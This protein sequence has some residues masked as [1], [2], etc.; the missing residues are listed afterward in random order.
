MTLSKIFTLFVALLVSVVGHAACLTDM[1][2]VSD[3]GRE[4]F[5]RGQYLLAAQQYSSV[6]LLSCPGLQQ[7]S[8]RLRWG[9]SL[10]ELEE[11]DE[12]RLI[13]EKLNG[14]SLERQAHLVQA[15]YQPSLRGRL[16]PADQ[17]KFTE[18]DRRDLS[19]L[20]VKIPWVAGTLS[21]LVPGAGQVYNGNF[22]SAVFS[23]LLN[24]IFLSTTLDFHNR[25]M[26]APAI[27]S[28]MVFS[29][30][31]LGNIIGSVRSAQ[32][33]NSAAQAPAEAELKHKLFPEL[34][35]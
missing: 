35:N 15:W 27:A 1:N 23:F 6:A 31:Y 2:A 4:F 14:T 16:T 10:Y 19:S 9:Q 7:Y 3:Q 13:L 25:H 33:L 18:W 26:D 5:S 29:V 21:A 24:A 34:N 17:I 22:Q 11:A 28:G 30:V 12:G 32:A 8:A 20:N